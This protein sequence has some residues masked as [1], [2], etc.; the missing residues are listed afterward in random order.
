VEHEIPPARAIQE[1]V[2]AWKALRKECC[3]R[4]CTDNPLKLSFV[5]TQR[6]IE[7]I[8]YAP[9]IRDTSSNPSLYQ[10]T[11]FAEIRFMIVPLG[12]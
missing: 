1:L 10:N 9:S 5:M 2:Q 11:D 12:D 6:V 8:S 3:T 4:F 7:S